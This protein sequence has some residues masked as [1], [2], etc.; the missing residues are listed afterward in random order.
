MEEFTLQII[1]AF[2]QESKY[3]QMFYIFV[4]AAK[5]FIFCIFMHPAN[6]FASNDASASI[7]YV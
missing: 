6:V 3:R 2:L 7:S 5:L 1:F 4:F